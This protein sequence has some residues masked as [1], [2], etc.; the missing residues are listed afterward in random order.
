MDDMWKRLLVVL[1]L[2]LLLPQLTVF[3]GSK[4]YA[5]QPEPTAT[6]QPEPVAPTPP[7][8]G[9]RTTLIPVL[10]SENLVLQMDLEEYVRGVVLAEMP[11]SFE[12]EAL[13]AQAVAAR[14]Y[15]LRRVTLGDRHPHGAVCTD[16]TCCQAWVSDGYY[17]ENSGSIQ[18]VEKTRTAVTATAGL[19]VTYGGVLA[20]TTYFSCS[21]GRTESAQAVWSEDI[22]YLQ[23]VDSPGE[24]WAAVYS[25][26][27]YFTAE[28]F[29]ACLGRTLT[30]SPASWLGPEV[31]T[32]GGG[33]ST[34]TI[35]GITYSGVELR[36]LLGL[37]STAFSITATG[38]GITVT[39]RGRG[40]RV[41]MSQYGAGAM[42]LDGSDFAAI[43]RHYYP[44]TEIDKI[45]RMG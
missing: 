16:S 20:E 28:E 5:A 45:D 27:Q 42:A 8:S 30:G 19:V 36:R 43:L 7:Q 24:E 29:A 6:R 25:S 13:K 32:P 15:A 22:P 31:R 3:I 40:H 35:G 10:M 9:E 21:G 38:E 39:A 12:L 17:L 33:V 18:D 26:T 4:Y 34:L 1:A 14:T 2:S 41:G 44:G 23:A 11:A 37:A